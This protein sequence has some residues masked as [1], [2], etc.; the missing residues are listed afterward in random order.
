MLIYKIFRADEWA[1]MQAAGQTLGAPVDRQDGYVHFSTA[2]QARETAARHF[3]GE[4]HLVLVT[5]DTDAMGDHLKWEVSRGGAKFPHL[6]APFHMDHVVAAV[7]LPLGPGG[8]RFP[9][10]T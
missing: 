2:D 8:H 3:A 9:D 7:P 10:L 1:G 5:A 6:Y 4:E